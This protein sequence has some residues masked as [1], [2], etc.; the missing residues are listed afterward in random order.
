MDLGI[1]RK[2]ALVG[3]S[4]GGLGFAC[5]HRLAREGCNVVL[6][7]KNENA[8]KSAVEIIH[9]EIDHGEVASFVVDLTTAE[10]IDQLIL[11]AKNKFGQV[12]IL[13]TNSG[14]P[15]SGNVRPGNR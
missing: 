12:D 15:P 2:T 8:L 6:C 1:D 3:A 7:D 4:A 11:E 10:E 14:G 13:V 9:N 5:A